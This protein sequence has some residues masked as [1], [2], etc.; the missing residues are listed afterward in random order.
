MLYRRSKGSTNN[1]V[2]YPT[3]GLVNYEV[4][5]VVIRVTCLHEPVIIAERCCWRALGRLSVVGSVIQAGMRVRLH[6]G[7]R[8][9][10]MS[11][12]SQWCLIVIT[13]TANLIITRTYWNS[14]ILTRLS[15]HQTMP[16]WDRTLKKEYVRRLP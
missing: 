13:T 12:D 16:W 15:L 9:A 5:N 2:D 6:E 14:T 8:G 7:D 4:K 10:N 1:G 11:M 3:R